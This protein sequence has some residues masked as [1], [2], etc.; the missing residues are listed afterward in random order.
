MQK[1]LK[2][3]FI[4]NKYQDYLNSKTEWN[5]TDEKSIYICKCRYES[6]QSLCVTQHMND[7]PNSIAYNSKIIIILTCANTHIFVWINFFLVVTYNYITFSCNTYIFF[8][9]IYIWI[10]NFLNRDGM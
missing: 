4:N 6:L 2:T 5:K 8:K 1:K 7:H 9:E 3:R 10:L